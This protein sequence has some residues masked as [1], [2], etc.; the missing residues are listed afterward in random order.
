MNGT[1]CGTCSA[2]PLTGRLL[3]VSHTPP[4]FSPLSLSQTSSCLKTPAGAFPSP[5]LI[6]TSSELCGSRSHLKSIRT[7]SR[8]QCLRSPVSCALLS[9]QSSFLGWSS[10]SF[11]SF[12]PSLVPTPFSRRN[13]GQKLRSVKEPLVTQSTNDEMGESRPEVV[14]R[15]VSADADQVDGGGSLFEV[16]IPGSQPLMYG[17][18]YCCGRAECF[19]ASFILVVRVIV[20]LTYATPVQLEFISIQYES[21]QKRLELDFLNHNLHDHWEVW[22]WVS[23]FRA[24]IDPAVFLSPSYLRETYFLLWFLSFFYLLT[25]S[26]LFLLLRSPIVSCFG[27]WAFWPA[28]SA[29]LI[30]WLWEYWLKVWSYF[31]S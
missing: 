28:V 10:S 1:T 27:L 20:T 26:H 6:P 24:S 16:T 11:H 18:Q 30:R 7:C 14:R 17:L 4:T 3:S 13:L 22:H 23:R 31:L 5:S 2:G 19:E 21:A 15:V 12:R 29:M 9:A 25:F 8:M